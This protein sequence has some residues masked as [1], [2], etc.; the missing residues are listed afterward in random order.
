MNMK[1]ILVFSLLIGIA[2]ASW[3]LLG[4]NTATTTENDI[5]LP[6]KVHK[7]SDIENVTDTSNDDVYSSISN[8]SLPE[9]SDSDNA[10]NN[11]NVDENQS[12]TIERLLKRPRNDDAF[13]EHLVKESHNAAL[14]ISEHLQLTAEV[15]GVLKSILEEKTMIDYE[16][17][18][19]NRHY[20]ETALALQKNQHSFEAKIRSELDSNEIFAYEQFELKKS[21]ELHEKKLSSRLLTKLAKMENLSEAQREELTRAY[22][23]I[24]LPPNEK[25]SIGA[26]GTYY[27]KYRHTV[28]NQGWYRRELTRV[29]KRFN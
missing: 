17:I 13:K 9:S 4:D 14:E 25:F 19:Q 8:H 3:Y 23:S 6:R 26:Y 10:I 24:D 2:V 18:N 16:I 21:L 1:A 28:L 22:D 20:T 12:S 29:N 27:G 15:S 11:N 7:V 5:E